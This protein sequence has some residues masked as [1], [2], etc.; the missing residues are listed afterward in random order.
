MRLAAL[1]VPFVVLALVATGCSSEPTAS[2]SGGSAPE[3][4]A[5][6]AGSDTVA[7]EPAEVAEKTEQEWQTCLS[8]EQFRILREKGT[9][10]AFTGKYYATKT[11]GVYHCAGCK[12]P[13]YSSTTK[14][15]SGTGWPSYWQPVTPDAVTTKTDESHGMI[16]TELLCSRCGGHLGHVFE[17]GPAP[18]G[19]RHCINS[20]ALEL[21]PA[22]PEGEDQP[23]E[24]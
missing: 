11:A 20:A 2:E 4:A 5:A 17:D 22:D 23:D 10:G 7:T 13:L 12:Q 8:P 24:E 16:R 9:E 3:D 6:P 19:L 14:F 1:P 21:V 15:D 18:T